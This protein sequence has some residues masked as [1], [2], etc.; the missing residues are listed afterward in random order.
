MNIELP[1]GGFP[2]IKMCN[3]TNEKKE[4]L[5]LIKERH[6]VSNIKN[7]NIRKIL[8]SNIKKSLVINDEVKDDDLIEV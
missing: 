1:N 2:P 5:E 4:N 3:I 8:N 7:I 6:I